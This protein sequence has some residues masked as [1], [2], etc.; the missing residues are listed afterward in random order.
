MGCLGVVWGTIWGV[1]GL[2]E[3]QF[4]VIGVKFEVFRFCMGYNLGW[5][6]I[7]FEVFGGFLW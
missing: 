3:V 7:K 1:L 4:G 2:F 5:I 6:G